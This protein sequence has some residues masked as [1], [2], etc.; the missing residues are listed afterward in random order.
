VTAAPPS[1]AFPHQHGDPRGL[2]ERIEAHLRERIA[3]AVDMAS[4][5]LMV[6]LRQRQGRPAPETT[7]DA[8]RREFEKLASDLLAHLREAFHADLTSEERAA[9]EQA[10]AAQSKP[11]EQRFAG[12]V[13]L[14]RRLPDY[15]QRFEAHVAVYEKTRLETSSP[16]T[17]SSWLSKLFGR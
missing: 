10:E 17:G 4:L 12:Q 6:D 9:L 2:V 7:S 1:G 15:W 3:E 11:E 16:G 14:A 13:F 8:D 5:K